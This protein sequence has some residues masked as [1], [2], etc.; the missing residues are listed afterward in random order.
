M[1]VT[2]LLSLLAKG[3]SPENLKRIGMLTDE[4]AQMPTL[5]PKPGEAAD[6]DLS[7]L[8]AVPDTAINIVN[9]IAR[10]GKQAVTG[11]ISRDQLLSAPELTGDAATI[12]GKIGDVV[13]AAMNYGGLLNGP[14]FT[15]NQALPCRLSPLMEKDASK[16]RFLSLATNAAASDRFRKDA[17]CNTYR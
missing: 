11:D 12:T 17:A 4:S 6:V 5:R 10:Y 15:R 9:D 8:T 14:T 16:P 7:A 3:M 1:A 2:G 13:G